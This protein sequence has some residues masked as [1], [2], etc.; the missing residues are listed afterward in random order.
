MKRAGTG[1]ARELAVAALALCVWG[2][3]CAPGVCAEGTAARGREVL[4][5]WGKAVVSVRLTMKMRMSAKGRQ[6]EEEEGT[7]EI[8]ATVIDPSGLAVCSLSEAD[9]TQM[10]KAWGGE[11]E[12][13]SWEVDITAVKLRLADGKE[14]SGK[15]VLRDKDLDLAF[16]RPTEKQAER[17][18]R[19]RP[20][21][22]CRGEAQDSVCSWAERAEF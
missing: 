2:G 7:Q 9:P 10:F 20:D 17:E 6:V 22:G 13:Y 21:L 18:R 12:G 4:S 19:A 14:I 15:I 5:K 3:W 8:R 11:A 1:K 16:I